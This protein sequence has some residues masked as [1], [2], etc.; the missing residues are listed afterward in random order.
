MVYSERLIHYTI[1]DRLTLIGGSGIGLES[2]GG[3]IRKFRLMKK[4]RLED[5]AEKAGLS[6]NYVGAIE[7]GEKVPSLEALIDIV[8]A[9]GISAD[10]VLCD[11]VH[12]GYEVRHSLLAER[13]EKL[14]QEDR[15]RIYDVIETL[16]RHSTRT[17]P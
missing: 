7:R 1:R 13:L 2:I 17:M 5:L 8:N 6:T 15:A 10:M 12:T 16:I 4:F 3:N 9:L 11:V 14:S